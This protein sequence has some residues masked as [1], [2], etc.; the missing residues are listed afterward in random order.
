[1][2]TLKIVLWLLFGIAMGG[3]GILLLV[4]NIYGLL[5]KTKLDRIIIYIACLFFVFMAYA[6]YN[7]AYADETGPIKIWE[8]FYSHSELLYHL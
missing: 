1:M 8:S 3:V 5:H 2:I 4:A 7:Q 6:A